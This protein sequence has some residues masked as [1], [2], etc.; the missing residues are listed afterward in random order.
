MLSGFL[1]GVYAYTHA[2]RFVFKHRLWGYVLVPGL[3]SLLL[4]IAIFGTAWSVSD[5][6]AT[7]LIEWYPWEWGRNAIEVTAQIFGGLSVAV[8]GLILF[9]HLVMA[10]SSP[11]MSLLSEK[12]ERIINGKSPDIP[13]TATQITKDTIRGLSLALRNIIRE[14]FYTIILLILGLLIPIISPFT[15]F[16]IFVIQAFYAGF[17]NMDYTLERYYQRRGSILFVK[18]YKSL[19][20]GNG[21]VFLL[22]L[23]TGVGFLFALPFSTIAA[24]TE[25]LKRLSL[26]V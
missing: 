2:F 5:N 16:L 17:G 3:I 26:E 8:I 22:M 1:N 6:I 10:I 14:L 12:V 19:A 24:T 21:T 20:V 4:G 13:F 23:F 15:S 25:T 11:V 9:K 7:W 18:K